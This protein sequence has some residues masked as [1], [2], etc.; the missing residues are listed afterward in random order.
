MRHYT[1]VRSAL[2]LAAI[3]TVASCNQT[4]GL[5]GSGTFLVAVGSEQFRVR[6]ENSLLA[7]QARRMANG[8]ERQ[9]IINGQLARGDGGFN[10]GYG[11]HIN[12]LTITLDEATVESCNENN[13]KPS[14]IQANITHWVDEVKRYCPGLGR[15]VSEIGRF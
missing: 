8:Q 1:L 13:A 2:T 12:P 3:L 6:I 11:W 15:F 10:T 4:V 5:A 14:D 7:N 9:K